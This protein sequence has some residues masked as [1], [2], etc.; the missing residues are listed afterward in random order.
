MFCEGFEIS[1][2]VFCSLLAV[3]AEYNLINRNI[4]VM[5]IYLTNLRWE[6]AVDNRL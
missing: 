3:A 2:Q 1:C 4:D 5:L 6:E